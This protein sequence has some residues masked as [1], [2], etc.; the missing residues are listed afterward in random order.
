MNKIPMCLLFILLFSCKKDGSDCSEECN[1][2]RGLLFQTGFEGTTLTEGKYHQASFTGTDSLLSGYNSWGDFSAHE[3]IGTVHISY[4]DGT[5]SERKATITADPELPGNKV[6]KFQLMKPHINEGFQKKGRVQLNVN[7]NNCISEIYQ[8]VR[9]RLHPDME[10]LKAWDERVAWLSLFEFWN[11]AD[12]TNEKNPFRVTVNLFKDKK[13]PVN[14]MYFHV[15]GDYKNDCTYCKWN[16]LWEELGEGFSVPFGEWMDIEIYIKE[17]DEKNGRFFMAVTPDSGEKIV[18]F[19]LICS[20]QHPDETCPDGFSH[21]QPM[22]LYTSDNLINYMKDAGK[23]LSVCW[24][25]WSF[26]INESKLY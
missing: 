15:K 2:Y 23:E 14:E 26:S 19:D 13:G 17:G 20:T 1:Y 18:I 12:W 10:W 21:L 11:N 5:D 16:L 6:L 9:L 22:K 25:D 7:E 8:K 3:N 4:E 24:D